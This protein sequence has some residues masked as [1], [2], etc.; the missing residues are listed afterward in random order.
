MTDSP[1]EIVDF[2]SK[3]GATESNGLVNG[4]D[5]HAQ[6]DYSPSAWYSLKDVEEA[7]GKITRLRILTERVPMAGMFYDV[8]YVN[9]TLPDGKI[10]AVDCPLSNMMPRK[11]FM[12]AL[13]DWAKAQ[14]VYAKGIG[15]L[16]KGNWSVLD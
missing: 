4:H 16:D 2:R 1:N 10:V 7:G 6:V 11:D 13:I 14:G 8:S 15:L 3:Y 12:G 5:Y 9:A